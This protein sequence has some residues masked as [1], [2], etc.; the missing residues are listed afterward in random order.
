MS[1][2]NDRLSHMLRVL[3]LYESNLVISREG[4]DVWTARVVR[5]DGSSYSAT[6]MDFFGSVRDLYVEV[7]GPTLTIHN[8]NKEC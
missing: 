8:P 4:G 3:T 6:A 2:H 7:I 5:G 1:C